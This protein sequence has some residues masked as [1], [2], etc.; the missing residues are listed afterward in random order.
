VEEATHLIAGH[1]LRVAYQDLPAPVVENTK[2][3]VLDFFGVALGGSAEAGV[4]ELR[5][6]L[7]EWGGAEQA[8]VIGSG[9]RLPVPHA[10]QIN[11]TMAHALDYDDVHEA[12]IMH[13]GVV[14]IPA[15]LAAAEYVGGTS[16]QELITA[17]ALGTDFICRLGL[18]TRP[19]ENIHQ[20]GWHLTSIYGYMTAAAVAGRILG[21]DRERLLNAMGIA[22]HQS[23]G[24][25]QCVKDGA[26][27]KRMGPG[28]AVRGGLAAA[29]MAARGITGARNCLEGEFGIYRVYHQGRYSRER[30][31]GEL[32]K[33]FE[34]VN[35]SIKPYPCCRG[36]HPFIDAALK[37]VH[38][39]AVEPAAV[40]RIRIACG[41]GTN[42]LLATP[43]EAKVRPRTPVD[44]QF[45]VP[46]GVAVALARKRA[47]I[48]DFSAEAIKSPD[49]LEMA[50]KIEVEVDPALNRGDEIEPGRVTVTV[51][52][53]SVLSRQVQFPTG[54]PQEPITFPECER[55]VRDCL[56]H[57]GNPLPEDRVNR[58]VETV[59]SLETVADVRELIGLT[60]PC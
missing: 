35:V 52:G 3:Q 43:F 11:A 40:E 21:L 57:A 6:L 45:S 10:A 37:L 46:W 42:L 33:R 14:T 2:K 1:F 28:F 23:A 47:T 22:Y 8:T 51:K 38:E 50:A 41:E 16:G 13:P 34:G 60:V 7:E 18:A 15:A 19:G 48:K 17:V 32:G 44:S 29:F 58:L 27:T 26:L 49:I 59:A 12:A 55:K 9:R 25:G 36:V 56:A 39:E 4:R 31:L 53:G 54:S 20:F 5:A 30:L 24:N